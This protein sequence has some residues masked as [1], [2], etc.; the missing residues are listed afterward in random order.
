MLVQILGFG[1]NWW[2]RYGNDANDRYRFTRHAA[3][4]NSTGV[5][6]GRTIR[7]HWVVPGLVRFNGGDG[8]EPGFPDS[9][10][11]KTFYCSEVNQFCGGNRLLVRRP[12]VGGSSP[13]RLLVVASSA[14]FGRVDFDSP[15]WKS[16]S[17]LVLA[18]T[19]LRAVQEIMLLIRIGEWIQTE[20]GLWQMI[21]DSGGTPTLQL[22]IGERRKAT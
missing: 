4:Y 18:A 5:R 10:V 12:A 21:P 19:M 3:V 13:E 9:L 22:L 15:A 16:P 1:S 17:T 2:A 8:Y 20:L 7:R 11:G 14:K 6:C